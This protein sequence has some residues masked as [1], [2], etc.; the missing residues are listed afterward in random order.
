MKFYK[1]FAFYGFLCSQLCF[2]IFDSLQFW[3]L[4]PLSLGSFFATTL[5]VELSFLR[6]PGF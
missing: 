6:E 2:D 4:S 5:V 1:D 3:V